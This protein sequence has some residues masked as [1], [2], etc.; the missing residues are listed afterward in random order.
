MK[1]LWHD[2]AREDMDE[3]YNFYFS[4]NPDAASRI[5]NSILDATEILKTHPQVAAVE[6]KLQGSEFVY[7]SL[8]VRAGLFKVVYY[9]QEDTIIITRVWCCRQDLTHFNLYR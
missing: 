5:Y 2:N 4:K 9:V 8:V 3:I 1:L 6:S 7:R